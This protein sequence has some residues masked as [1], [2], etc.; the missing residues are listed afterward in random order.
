MRPNEEFQNTERKSKKQVKTVKEQ[1]FRI[2]IAH[3]ISL[4]MLAADVQ[5]LNM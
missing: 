4:N 3:R 1:K 2:K 5:Q